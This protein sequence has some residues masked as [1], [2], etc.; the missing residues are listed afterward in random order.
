IRVG[1]DNKLGFVEFMSLGLFIAVGFFISSLIHR[2]ILNRLFDIL[3]SEPGT[4]NTISRIVHYTII[5]LA[6]LLGLNA[7][8]L[9]QFIF[10]IGAPF[11]VALGFASKDIVSDLLAGFFVLI[12]RP[13]EIG[14]YVQ[15]DEVHGTVH[16]IDARSTTIITSK[17]HSVII[18]N[19]DL[20]TKW[21]VNWGHG[22]FAVGFELNVRVDQIEDPEIVRKLLLSVVSTNQFIL[23]V[24]AVVARLEDI[25]Q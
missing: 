10:W 11:A 20:I 4:Q 9:G 16:K 6:S 2:F 25:E 23:K 1:V 24:P 17:N 15:I 3:R 19:K 12:E 7:V 14:N 13:I 22:R 5:F 18:P 8:H 21:V